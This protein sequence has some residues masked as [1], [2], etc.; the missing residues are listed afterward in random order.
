MKDALGFVAVKRVYAVVVCCFAVQELAFSV[1]CRHQLKRTAEAYSLSSVYLHVCAE[2]RTDK[3]TP[4]QRLPSD[5]VRLD[6]G[7]SLGC[8]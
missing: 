1:G 3:S 6:M 7:V 4:H 8:V 5:T 2:P